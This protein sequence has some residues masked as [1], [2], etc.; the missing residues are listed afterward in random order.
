MVW[1][2]VEMSA[3]VATAYGEGEGLVELGCDRVQRKVV[4]AHRRGGCAHRT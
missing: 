3:L 1:F 2:P 4:A